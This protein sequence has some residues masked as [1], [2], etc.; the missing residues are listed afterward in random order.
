MNPL[1]I[2]AAAAAPFA[3]TRQPD[4]PPAP[5][6]RAGLWEP[7]NRHKTLLAIGTGLLSGRSF[8]E[9]V[10]QAGA[11]VMGLGDQLDARARKQRE[12]GGPDDAF[13]IITDPAT[14]ERSVR[15]VPVFQDYLARKRVK[16]KDTADINGRAMYALGQLPEADRPAAYAAMRANPEQY[17]IDPDSMP[18]QY[19][20]RYVAL[21]GKMGMTVAQAQTREQAG[22]NAQAT[23]AYRA[24]VQEDRKERTG[25]YR[26][27]SNAAT[28]QGE[29]RIGIAKARALPKAKP[30]GR[31]K[32]KASSGNADLSYLLK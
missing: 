18:E 5:P 8:G 23:A 30:A 17:G 4:L 21:T 14:G 28:A 7:G 25:I 13:E 32:A 29:A 6:A 20:P 24:D 26:A 10:A 22:A 3:P 16:V 11:N 12:F 31:G 19:D 27:R 9:G 15:Q 1:L 2:P